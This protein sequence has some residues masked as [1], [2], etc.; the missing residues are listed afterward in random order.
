[1]LTDV[2][3]IDQKTFKTVC[4]LAMRNGGNVL[5]FGPSGSGKTFIAQQAAEEEGYELIYINLSV[6]ERTDF[7]GFPVISEDKSVVSYASPNFMPFVDSSTKDEIQALERF[8]ESIAG[9]NS[10]KGT[11]HIVGWI[12]QRTQQLQEKQFAEN[13]LNAS[14]WVNNSNNDSVKKQFKLLMN[15]IEP[16]LSPNK[17]KIFCFDEV[18]KALTETNQTLLELLQ[19]SSINARKLNIKA[20]ILTGNLPDE[21]AHT[22]QISHAISKRCRTFKLQIDFQQWRDWAFKNKVHTNIVQFLSQEPTMIYKTASDDVTAYALPSPRTWTDAGEALN[23]F[24]SDPYLA[25][26]SDESA[27]EI[28]Y[29]LVAGCVGEQA[30]IK[31]V[32]WYKHYRI[33][34][35]IVN[36]LI[37]TGKHPDLT[38]RSGQE[39]LIMAISACSKAFSELRPKNSERIKKVYT[40]VYSWMDVL[41]PDVQIGAVRLSFGGDFNIVKEH[42]LTEIDMF[43]KIINDLAV[44]F[45]HCNAPTKYNPNK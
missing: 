17:K 36:E 13:I 44:K 30:A 34:D 5:V 19:F 2:P 40:N 11:D 8:N 37:E 33:L 35:P 39:V 20:C 32:N 10:K 27:D 3:T 41:P 26:M 22:N 24:E 45:N 38:N 15:Q 43:M 31:F 7:Q 21:H 42:S 29:S 1:M 6:L 28:M 16:T 25:S 18:D 23:A 12:K 9:L 14:R 4:R